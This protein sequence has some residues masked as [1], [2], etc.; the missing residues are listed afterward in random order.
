MQYFIWIN[1]DEFWLLIIITITLTPTLTKTTGIQLYIL[2][3]AK[4]KAIQS[5]LKG[6]PTN[7][8]HALIK[9]TFGHPKG[10]KGRYH[11]SKEIPL[12]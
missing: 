1:V 4:K 7:L 12:I 11:S 6:N 2:R 5:Q 10:Y 3:I 9:A 8:N